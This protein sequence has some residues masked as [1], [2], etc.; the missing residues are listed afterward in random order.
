MG[1]FF[2][3][4]SLAIAAFCLAACG[5]ADV[6]G[7]IA[8]TSDGVEKRADY[9]LS[10][11]KTIGFQTIISHQEEYQL[12]LIGDT[13]FGTAENFKKVEAAVENSALAIVHVGDICT[14]K[15]DDYQKAAELLKN[16]P[17]KIFPLVGNHDLYFGGWQYFKEYFGSSMFYF[18]VQTPTAKDLHV[19]LDSGNG[20]LGKKQYDWLKNLLA[21]KRA[22][23]RRCFVYSHTNMFRTDG[24]Q[25]PSSNM[26]IEETY[27]L[28]ALYG[29]H[30]VDAVIMGHDHSREELSF[31]KVR[32]ITLDAL[33]DG[34]K[35]ASYLILTANTSFSYQFIDLK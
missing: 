23:Y 2:K 16:S 30:K 27:Q 15:K 7:M 28:M 5:D 8:S 3:K 17:L 24:S 34:V 14:G 10:L 26:P 21:S 13:H 22:D 4:I 6:I 32:Y 20:T 9:S 29:K 12:C 31:N 18:E 33:R 11:N 19:C 35:N 1:N 25:S